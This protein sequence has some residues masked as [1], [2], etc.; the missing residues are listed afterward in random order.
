[1]RGFRAG[2]PAG[3]PVDG[4]DVP[5]SIISLLDRVD[6]VRMSLPL[7]TPPCGVYI[8]DNQ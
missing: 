2:K 3:E 4:T 5:Q 8:E 6:P 1:M 7:E